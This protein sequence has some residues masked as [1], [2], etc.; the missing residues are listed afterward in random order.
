MP[1]GGQVLALEQ[2]EGEG[3]PMGTFLTRDG[4]EIFYKGWGTGLA[5]DLLVTLAASCPALAECAQ[6]SASRRKSSDNFKNS[7]PPAAHSSAA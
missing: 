1:T 3:P 2:N 7:T 6:I 5:V 4:T